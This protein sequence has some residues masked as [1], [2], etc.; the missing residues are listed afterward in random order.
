M[1]ILGSLNFCVY[2]YSI[3]N[4]KQ[5]QMSNLQNQINSLAPFVELVI[6]ETG[7]SLESDFQSIM[8]MAIDKQD[9]AIAKMIKCKDQICEHIYDKLKAA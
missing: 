2:L 4:N 8:V 5:Q 9:R 6:S 3:I 1:K 7:W